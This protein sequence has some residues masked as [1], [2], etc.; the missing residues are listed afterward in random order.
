MGSPIFLHKPFIF[1]CFLCF[2]IGSLFKSTSLRCTHDQISEGNYTDEI[3]SQK[4]SSFTVADVTSDVST[5]LAGDNYGYD[6]IG[7]LIKDTKEGITNIEWTVYGKISKIIKSNASIYY[8]YDAA[9]NRISKTV[10]TA[11]VDKTTYYVLDAS[12]NVMSVYTHE[13][14][15]TNNTTTAPLSQTELHLYGSSRLGVYNV[16]VDV[17]NCLNSEALVTIF[18]RANKFFELSNHLGNV[19]VTISDKKLQHTANNSTVDYYVADVVTANDYYP[20]GM[21]MPGRK[22]AQVGG[23]RYGF[24]GKENDN[25]TG[26]GNLDFGAR[27]MDVKLG[28]WLSVDPLEKKYTA[29]SPYNFAINNPIIVIDIDGRDIIIVTSTGNY[30]RAAKTLLKTPDGKA[31]WNKY[32]KNKNYDIYITVGK[33]S[34]DALATTVYGLVYNENVRGIIENG[35]MQVTN[36]GWQELKEFE[37]VN[38]SKSKG[39]RT[40]FIILNQK[41]FDEDNSESSPRNKSQVNNITEIDYNL[42]EAIFHEI[43]SHIDLHGAKPNEH[44]AY[45]K[46]SSGVFLE[47]NSPEPGK[48]A[49]KIKNQLREEYNKGYMDDPRSTKPPKETSPDQ[50]IEP[51]YG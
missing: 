40:T 31:L 49:E 3:N 6:A 9:G 20:F 15:T 41:G 10:S 51:S 24:N 7:N 4:P 27:I 50:N 48:P 39:R 36:K 42:A 35:K 12:G 23:Y 5:S 30:K 34:D 22:F 38:V 43:K 32:A 45:G 46:K 29:F 1:P 16:K 33:T 37:G 13:F 19:L 17:Q 8:N 14:N 47:S 25:S 11:G 28:R 26:E 18:T 21:Q 2:L 44:D